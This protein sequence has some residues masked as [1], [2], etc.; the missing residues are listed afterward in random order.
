MNRLSNSDFSELISP[1]AMASYLAIAGVYVSVTGLLGLPGDGLGWPGQ[2]AL[3]AFVVVWLT[4]LITDTAGHQRRAVFWLAALAISALGLLTLGRTNTG[5]ILLVL[6]ATMVVSIFPGRRALLILLAINVMFALILHF[7]WG[8]AWN[9]IL[10]QVMTFG[11]FQAFAALII[12]YARRAELAAEALREVNAKLMATRSLLGETARDQERLRLS[13]ELHDVAGHKLTAIKLNLHH[14]ARQPGL[15]ASGELRQATSLAGDLLEDL[16]AVVRQLRQNDGIDLALGIRQLIEPLPTP[17]VALN[18][19]PALRVPRAEQAETLLR[20]IQEGLTN[21]AR[22]GRARHAWL[23][24]GR[25]GDQLR[26]CL[27]DDGR[28]DWPLTPGN[29]LSIMRERLVELGGDLELA[30]SRRGGLSLT[31]RLPLESVP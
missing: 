27:E 24:L 5:P 29:G 14:L 7:R 11:A 18:L 28:L 16:R 22:H 8:W 25:D 30:P 1:L 2:V 3:L 15:A 13:R 4:L 31:A 9:W 6:L 26:L 23:E 19:D 20:V 17:T 12:H 21:A 10:T